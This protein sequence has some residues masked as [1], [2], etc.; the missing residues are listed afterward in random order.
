VWYAGAPVDLGTLPNGLRSGARAVNDAGQI[1]GW[2]ES[3]WNTNNGLPHAV[4][5]QGGAIIDLTPTAY[6]AIALGIND[7]GV[8]VGALMESPGSQVNNAFI[9]QNGILTL[10]P[11]GPPGT[12]PGSYAN[13]INASGVIAGY[14]CTLCGLGTVAFLHSAGAMTVL[15]GLLAGAYGINDNGEVAGY[16]NDH[17]A[18]W[19]G[20]APLADAGGPYTALEG[21]SVSF[22]GSGS[23]DADSDPLT[24]DWDFGD[25]SPHG[26]GVT[27]SHTYVD[28][29]SYTVTLT[30]SD[31][32]NT[33][34]ITTSASVANVPPTVTLTLQTAPPIHVG[35]AF[36]L[37][38]GFHD[39]GLADGSWAY[40]FTRNGTLLQQGSKAQQPPMGVTLP[41]S[42][43]I[44][45][46]GTYTF[47][48]LVRDKDG[49]IG[50]ASVHVQVVP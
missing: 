14:A 31:G 17:A 35:Q 34:A 11:Y 48:L 5:W 49:G 38:G 3:D 42:Q 43:T 27:P 50:T 18:L 21:I 32:S 33:G 30:V 45:T 8:V 29:G 47:K 6:S 13:D 44:G 15:P 16:V 36:T 2:S 4:L 12:G 19:R 9:W 40:R 1:V 41:V 37:R 10:I 24:Y 23:S 25:G 39:S 20:H 46:V 28:N 26:S 7:A 22:D